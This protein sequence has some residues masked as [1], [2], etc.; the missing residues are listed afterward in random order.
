[1]TAACRPRSLGGALALIAS[2]AHAQPLLYSQHMPEGTV[3]IRFASALPSPVSVGTNFAGEVALGGDRADRISPYFVAGAAGGTTVALQ[4]SHDGR[5]ASASFRPP[6]GAF[7]T[8]V[9]H[10]EGDGVRA[11]VVRDR[12]EYNQL[13]ARLSFYNATADCPAG[14]L[15]AGGQALFGGVPPDAGRAR[16][17][18]PAAATVTASCTA[19]TTP[20]LALGQLDAG[21]LYTVWMMRLAGRLTAFMGRDLIAPPRS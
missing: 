20:A 9:L 15:E 18:N 10:G 1:M 3:Y 17:V 5:T 7:V 13:K 12:P 8:V 19:G 4:V 21:G 2:A 11:A 6:S 14:S 16:S